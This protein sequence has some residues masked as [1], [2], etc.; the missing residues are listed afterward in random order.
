MGKKKEEPTKEESN[1]D[2]DAIEREFK[3]GQLSVREIARQHNISHTYINKSAKALGWKRD[4]TEKVSRAFRAQ[5]AVA[6]I[7]EADEKAII[8][9]AAARGVE[10]VKLHRKSVGVSQRLVETLSFQLCQAAKHRE[11]IEEDI[12]KD[13]SGENYD[14]KRRAAMM[15]AVSLP[16]H[17]ATLR[18]LSTA[19]KNLIALERQAFG[20]NGHN[21]GDEDEQLVT[22][23]VRGV[24]SAN[25]NVEVT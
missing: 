17:A 15:R 23:N 22:I 21:P 10:V 16:S 2:W 14:V 20:L 9:S 25:V 11:E 12:Y 19:Q 24:K 5:L 4:L 13:T 6:D 3:A 1:I 7:T 8:E 18:D